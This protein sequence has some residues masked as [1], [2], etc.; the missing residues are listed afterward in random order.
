MLF[1]KYDSNHVYTFH[2]LEN[3]T[4]QPKAKPFGR[5][6]TYYLLWFGA[7]PVLEPHTHISGGNITSF[8]QL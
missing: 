3:F 5:K 1:S 6:Y 7:M 8:L 2:V 4:L